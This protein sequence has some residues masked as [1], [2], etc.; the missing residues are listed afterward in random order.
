VA[1]ILANAFFCTYATRNQRD[2][3]PRINFASYA[4]IWVR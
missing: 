4:L 2:S 3:F 1:C